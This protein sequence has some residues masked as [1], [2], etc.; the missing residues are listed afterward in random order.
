MSHA[1][2]LNRASRAL[3][4]MTYYRGIPGDGFIDSF[5]HYNDLSRHTT[6]L[7]KVFYLFRH[8][9]TVELLRA[10]KAFKEIVYALNG[11]DN[12]NVFKVPRPVHRIFNN[13]LG[14]KTAN[15]IKL[16]SQIRD[17]DPPKD[18]NKTHKIME[19]L[20]LLSA[21]LIEL[22]QQLRLLQGSRIFHHP[23]LIKK[24]VSMESDSIKDASAV[25]ANGGIGRAQIKNIKNVVFNELK[26]QFK[27]R[28][29]YRDKVA[30]LMG[31][32]AYILNNY[33]ILSI[34]NGGKHFYQMIYQKMNEMDFSPTPKAKL[35]L[36]NCQLSE[37]LLQLPKSFFAQQLKSWANFKKFN[38]QKELSINTT[39]VFN[40][41]LTEA[42]A[43]NT[44]WLKKLNE[45]QLIKK[46]IEPFMY[47][48]LNNETW[49]KSQQT[50][51]FVNNINWP[52]AREQFQKLLE[53]KEKNDEF[54]RK[55]INYTSYTLGGFGA[56]S[57]LL[58][59]VGSITS[60]FLLGTS[61]T[62]YISGKAIDHYNS[63]MYA[64]FST[65]LYSASVDNGDYF[66]NNEYQE[67]RE[68]DFRGLLLAS[69]LAVG[70]I[71]VTIRKIVGKSIEVFNRSGQK[72]IRISKTKY[73]QLITKLK[74]SAH[75]VFIESGLGRSLMQGTLYKTKRIREVQK[76]LTKRLGELAGQLGMPLRKF[77]EKIIN[78]AFYYKHFSA[79]NRSEFFSGLKIEIPTDILTVLVAEYIVRREKFWEEAPFVIMNLLSSIA[80]TTILVS[81][82]F[83]PYGLSV[84]DS[85]RPRRMWDPGLT[86]RQRFETYIKSGKELAITSIPTQLGSAISIEAYL[87]YTLEKNGDDPDWQEHVMRA[88]YNT[89]YNSI[90][91]GTIS[92][93][94]TQGIFRL[95]EV[96][97]EKKTRNSIQIPL[98]YATSTLSNILGN[99]LYA[100]IARGMGIQ[101]LEE[102]Y[103]TPGY[104]SIE[105]NS[106]NAAFLFPSIQF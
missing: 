3:N 64:D 76:V 102:E 77:K 15:I 69:I 47:L 8:Y 18:I 84:A 11:D 14:H 62:L 24:R 2:E 105:L 57:I 17:N 94:K 50:F 52:R 9:K 21:Q 65:K 87:Y 97:T 48:A 4:A 10:R 82:S 58:P 41:V 36:K 25:L 100:G 7:N 49:E 92:N 90:F 29:D 103:T 40:S 61:A 38:W 28:E 83:R 13:H 59:F 68:A 98:V 80:L 71:R 75:P 32:K 27:S 34:K 67:V 86:P 16:I 20:A 22:D 42:I 104:H 30:E 95:N 91:M 19:T 53:K 73:A 78:S 79:T 43:N 70:A 44:F 6:D 89:V 5:Y 37:N 60:T 56:I 101:S 54:R 51:P 33:P 99:T 12:E 46:N 106:N 35:D 26:F 45:T 66:K 39:K 63:K 23:F 81:Q 1:N 72:Y 31:Q 85:T 88:I 74:G 96:L 93:L 55:L